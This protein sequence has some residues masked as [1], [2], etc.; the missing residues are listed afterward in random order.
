MAR[1]G[2]GLVLPATGIGTSLS[3]IAA[4]QRGATIRLEGR[5][6]AR[7]RL[8]VDNTRSSSWTGVSGV[9]GSNLS[10]I[11]YNVASTTF[12]ARNVFLGYY[13]AGTERA[14][15]AGNGDT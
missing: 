4:D 6:G 8:G 11:T 7:S 10:H 3:G 1:P 14:G 12:F 15:R 9:R 2:Q 5:P 13:Q